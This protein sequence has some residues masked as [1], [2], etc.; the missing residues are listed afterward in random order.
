M[1]LNRFIA[2][3]AYMPSLTISIS[4]CI[5]TVGS[6]YFLRLYASYYCLCALPDDCLLTVKIIAAGIP[7]GI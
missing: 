1:Y 5:I 6:A 3:D 4:K 2:T 7:T